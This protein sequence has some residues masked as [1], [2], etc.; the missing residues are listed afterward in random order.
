[1]SL[2]VDNHTNR[3]AASSSP[4]KYFYV[5]GIYQFTDVYNKGT[6]IRLSYITFYNWME[7]IPIGGEQ[8]GGRITEK[9]EPKHANSFKV[10]IMWELMNKM[11]L[12]LFD[13]SLELKSSMHIHIYREQ[14]FIHYYKRSNW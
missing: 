6:K 2:N 12:S 8:I 10:T 13:V 1:M 5:L 7:I 11:Y 9:I 4:V 3:L 14:E